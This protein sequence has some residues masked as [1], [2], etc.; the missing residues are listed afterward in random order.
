MTFGDPRILRLPKTGT[1][2]RVM[3]LNS[4]NMFRASYWTDGRIIAPMLPDQPDL[5]VHRATNELFW[6]EDCKVVR[7]PRKKLKGLGDESRHFQGSDED[8]EFHSDIPFA[9][10]PE[11]ADLER[12]LDE[13]MADTPAR[14]RYLRLRL[15]WT[16]NDALRDPDVPLTH[17]AGFAANLHTLIRLFNTR[18]GVDRLLAAEAHRELGNFD[19]A[20][21]LL[22]RRINKDLIPSAAVIRTLAQQNDTR[23]R[24]I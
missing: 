18:S 9:D 23:V 15:W 16:H 4:G 3:T 8:N 13:G 6:V 11:P 7:S 22:S 19:Q 20:L 14:H 10:D 1:L 21:T 5:M 24:Q 17:P 12:A 2:T